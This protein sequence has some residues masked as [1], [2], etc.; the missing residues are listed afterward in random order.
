[1]TVQELK[2]QIHNEFAGW[3]DE[4]MRKVA[5]AFPLLCLFLTVAE[6]QQRGLLAPRIATRAEHSSCLLSICEQIPLFPHHHCRFHPRR[7]QSREI[8]KVE[9]IRVRR[10][11][12]YHCTLGYSRIAKAL[13]GRC[14]VAVI[15]IYKGPVY[16]TWI[17][18][19]NILSWMQSGPDTFRESEST[20][21][22]TDRCS[23]ARKI[24]CWVSTLPDKTTRRVGARSQEHNVTMLE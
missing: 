21:R 10:L 14:T 5:P 13:R 12:P 22:S 2:N 16:P 11:S 24:A 3:E 9:M 19:K 20:R 6:S 1:M 4:L 15:M 8:H 17:T 18:T 7:R 23:A